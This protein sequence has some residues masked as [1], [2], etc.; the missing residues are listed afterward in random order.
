[1]KVNAL[2]PSGKASFSI[3]GYQ[4]SLLGGWGGGWGAGGGGGGGSTFVNPTAAPFGMGGSTVLTQLAL[5]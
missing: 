1:M 3:V 4:G 2:W 5:R